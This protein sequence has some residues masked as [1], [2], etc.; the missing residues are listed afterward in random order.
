MLFALWPTYIFL[1]CRLCELC[2]HNAWISS[3]TW[4]QRRGVLHKN[5]HAT[6]RAPTNT[7]HTFFFC[8]WIIMFEICTRKL[9]ANVYLKMTPTCHLIHSVMNDDIDCPVWFIHPQRI[10][11]VHVSFKIP[12]YTVYV[13]N[14]ISVWIVLII[15]KRSPVETCGH[16]P[17]MPV[18]VGMRCTEHGVRH[19]RNTLPNWHKIAD[20]HSG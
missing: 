16:F 20:E 2:V 10:K 6:A 13:C 8:V 9:R 7:M 3:W 5:G 1:M 18:S 14:R 19:W 17:W 11:Y 15:T 12:Q 4:Q